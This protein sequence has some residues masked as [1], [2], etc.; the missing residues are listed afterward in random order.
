MEATNNG[1]VRSGAGCRYISGNSG[2]IWQEFSQKLRS[3]GTVIVMEKTKSFQIHR[4]H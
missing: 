4:R 1:G 3:W 2:N